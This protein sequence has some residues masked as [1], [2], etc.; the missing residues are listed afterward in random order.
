MEV[1]AFLLTCSECSPQPASPDSLAYGD[2]D[3][4]GRVPFVYILHRFGEVREG[5][6]LVDD[7]R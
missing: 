3:L 7:G 5:M 2:Y 4:P 1:R 6:D